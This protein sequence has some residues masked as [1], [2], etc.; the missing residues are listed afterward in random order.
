[1]NKRIKLKKLK[2]EFLEFFDEGEQEIYINIR[3][4]IWDKRNRQRIGYKDNTVTETLGSVLVQLTPEV[5]P[6]IIKITWDEYMKLH[7]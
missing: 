4:K 6:V 3:G 7:G 1:M 2:Q 5:K